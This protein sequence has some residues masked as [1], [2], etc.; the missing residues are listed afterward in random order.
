MTCLICSS[1]DK[2]GRDVYPHGFM[3]RSCAYCFFC[4][5]RGRK[6]LKKVHD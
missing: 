6:W 3:C 1:E 4:W 2:R 5:K